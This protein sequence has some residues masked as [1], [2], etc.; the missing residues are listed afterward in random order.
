M[1]VMQLVSDIKADESGIGR[2][3][4]QTTQTHP[5][6]VHVVVFESVTHVLGPVVIH[7]PLVHQ[8]GCVYCLEEDR[9]TDFGQTRLYFVYNVHFVASEVRIY[10]CGRVCGGVFVLVIIIVY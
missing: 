5:G 6:K 1:A 9:G 10:I 4:H 2:L 7:E 3:V 8:T